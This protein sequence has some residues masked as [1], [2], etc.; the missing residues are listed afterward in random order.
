MHI[1]FFFTNKREKLIAN[2]KGKKQSCTIMRYHLTPVRIP[3]LKSLQIETCLAVQW[4]RHCA[5]VQ[6]AQV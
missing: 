4:L 1:T 6:R 3:I 5:S 2:L